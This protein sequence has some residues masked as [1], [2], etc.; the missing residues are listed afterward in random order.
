[1]HANSN[2]LNVFR[3]CS[4]R[5]CWGCCALLG[6]AD[7][8]LKSVSIAFCCWVTW[9]A[10]SL[11]EVVLSSTGLKYLE[12]E[13]RREQYSC[14][15][16]LFVQEQTTKSSGVATAFR[17]VLVLLVKFIIN[18]NRG[19]DLIL[20]LVRIIITFKKFVSTYIKLAAKK[21]L[22]I[23]FPSLTVESFRNKL[24]DCKQSQ[25]FLLFPLLISAVK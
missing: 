1:M 7:L 6:K 13:D 20:T 18:F 21:L 19:I 14:C 24:Q 9:M 17:V 5:K 8:T 12:E 25:M 15:F 3:D 16:R 4:F 22:K 23:V 10:L 11:P 2:R